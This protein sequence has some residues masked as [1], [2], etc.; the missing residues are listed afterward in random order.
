MLTQLNQFLLEAGI[1]LGIGRL[2]DQIAHLRRSRGAGGGASMTVRSGKIA[3]RF[4]P[5]KVADQLSLFDQRNSLRS[6]ALVVDRVVAKQALA[7]DGRY[8]RIV[9]NIDEIG[10]HAGFVAGRPFPGGAGVLAEFGLLAENVG[11]N[12]VAD[13]YFGGVAGEQHRPTVFLIHH[14]RFAHRLQ[15]GNELPRRVEEFLTAGQVLQSGFDV[16]AVPRQ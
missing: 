11:L 6:Y 13:H 12:Q 7:G 15:R 10:Q 16:A 2:K 3:N 5:H 1:G 9:E 4:A 14:R 8:R